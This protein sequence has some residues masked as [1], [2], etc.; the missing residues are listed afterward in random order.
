M[1]ALLSGQAAKALN[2]AFDTHLFSKGLPIGSVTVRAVPAQVELAGGATTLAL[3]SGAAAALTSLGVTAAPVD[4]AS[5]GSGG[6]SFPITGGKLN[7]K[8]FAGSVPHSGGI[9]L[10]KGST[11]VELTS[12]TINIDSDPDL[13]ALVGGQRVSILNLDLSQLDAQV[14]GR[15]ITL[16]GVR[17]TLTAGGRAGPQRGVLDERLHGGPP[18]RDRDRRGQGPLMQAARASAAAVMG[19]RIAYG[20]ALIAAPERLTRSWL[21]DTAEG[22]GGRVALRALGAREVL[23]HAGALR[24]SLGGGSALPWLAVSA[25]GDLADIASTVAERK[26][27]PDGSARATAVVAGGSA[28]ITAA[29]AAALERCRELTPRRR[30]PR[31]ATRAN[32]CGRTGKRPRRCRVVHDCPRAQPLDQRPDDAR[33]DRA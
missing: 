13:T 3:D 15:R 20:V 26:G 17:A 18:A 12:F 21:G 29:V 24:A 1:R 16:G 25:G 14:K 4:P 7:A 2:A 30:A 6:L 9:S 5:A 23:L 33:V 11:V 19:L 10:S 31:A 8:T 28:L 27:L 22:A 32:G